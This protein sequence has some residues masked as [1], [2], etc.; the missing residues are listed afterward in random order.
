MDYDFAVKYL[1]NVF[2]AESSEV[3]RSLYN[4]EVLDEWAVEHF[5]FRL[6]EELD[7]NDFLEACDGLLPEKMYKMRVNFGRRFKNAVIY[8]HKANV[9]GR[10]VVQLETAP[11]G[12]KDCHKWECEYV[13]PRI[14]PDI[15]P[16]DYTN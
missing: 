3:E 5:S 15:L 7:G 4:N 9:S 12:E 16:A 8:S 2:G 1:A 14:M 10:E 13:L 11:V 6:E